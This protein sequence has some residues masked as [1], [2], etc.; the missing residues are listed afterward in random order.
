MRHENVYLIRPNSSICNHN[1]NRLDQFICDLSDLVFHRK[2][3][4]H[5]MQFD[6]WFSGG[7]WSREVSSRTCVYGAGRRV[8]IVSYTCGIIS[9]SACGFVA[10]NV[11]IIT[12]S[13][14]A[15]RNFT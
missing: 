8:S 5:I 6:Q 13:K 2:I 15:F 14:D 7:H 4:R 11:R 10:R 3:E 12:E 9:K 1:Y